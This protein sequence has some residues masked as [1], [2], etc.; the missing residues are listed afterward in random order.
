MMRKVSGR[1][2]CATHTCTRT[3]GDNKFAGRVCGF[4][5]RM[6]IV[7]AH[8]PVR[9]KYALGLSHITAFGLEHIAEDTSDRSVEA[10]FVR[11]VF[12]YLEQPLIHWKYVEVQLTLSLVV[13][14]DRH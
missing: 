9:S 14:C 1:R 7:G 10:V 12:A 4:L 11:Y 2:F 5:W 13:E 6:A 8:I 3:A